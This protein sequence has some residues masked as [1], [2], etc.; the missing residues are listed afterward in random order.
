V[1]LQTEGA[2]VREIAFATTFHHWNDMVGIPQA[3]SGTAAQ[4]PIEK[5]LEPGSASETF[6]LPL[7][8]QAVDSAAGANAAI[9]L[10]YAFA[11]IARVAAQA[12]LLHAPGGTKS[13]ATLRHLQIAPAAQI[14]AVDAGRKASPIDPAA[15]HSSFRTHDALISSRRFF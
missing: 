5:K 1:A 14:P 7:S 8:I 11:N 12:P 3:L 2:N 13:Y 4:A 15:R 10:Q 6:Q 9:A